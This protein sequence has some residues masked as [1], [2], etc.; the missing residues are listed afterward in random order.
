MGPFVHGSAKT[1]FR[2]LKS[3]FRGSWTVTLYTEFPSVW[4][5]FFNT[6]VER[7]RFLSATDLRLR[8]SNVESELIAWLELGRNLVGGR[9][10][11]SGRS[12]AEWETRVFPTVAKQVV[13]TNFRRF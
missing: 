5:A 1:A 8:L 6:V 13:D 3:H 11:G 9:G 10:D 2:S 7:S 12:S 4:R